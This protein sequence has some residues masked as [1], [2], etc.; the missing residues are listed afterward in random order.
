MSASTC[1]RCGHDAAA[2][3][4]VGVKDHGDPVV[5]VTE[6]GDCEAAGRFCP[7]LV[8]HLDDDPTEP[9]IDAVVVEPVEERLRAV[10]VAGGITGVAA[11]LLLL[12]VG[13][14]LAVAARWSVDDRVTGALDGTAL[15]CVWAAAVAGLLARWAIRYGI[16]R[17]D[18][19]D[20]VF[21]DEPAEVQS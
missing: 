7:E 14:G 1:V 5:W 18:D 11:A 3:P 21:V 12:V 17:P 4:R 2:H 9:V 15:L 19:A 6:C 20:E 16:G 8:L 10:L 13:F